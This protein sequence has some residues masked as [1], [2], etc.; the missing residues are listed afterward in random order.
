[1]KR[2]VMKQIAL[3]FVLLIPLPTAS[4]KGK[5]AITLREIDGRTWL[6]DTKGQPFFAHGVTHVGY[7]H[8]GEDVAEIARELKELGFNSYGYGCPD[9]LKSD[10]PYVQDNNEIALIAIYRGKGATFF[11]IFDP[12]EQAR[13]D[14][15]IEKQCAANRNNPNLIGYC[16]TDLAAW[17]L[18]NQTGT[19]WVEYIR[20]LP[21]QSHGKI[22]YQKFLK[23]WR[24]KDEQQRDLAFLTLIAREYFKVCGEANRRYDPDHLVFGDRYLFKTA[25]P[26]VIKESLPYI[27][28][29]AIQPN[30]KPGFPRKDFDRIHK[31]T[32]KPIILC[33]FK[34]TFKEDGRKVLGWKPVEN[35]SV[36]GPMYAQY[37]KGAFATPYIIGSFWCQPVTELKPAFYPSGYVKVG[38][39]KP[40][41]KPRPEFN[42]AV[43]DVNRYIAANAPDKRSRLNVLMIAVDDLRPELACYGAKHVLSPNFDRLASTGVR[44]DRAYCQQAVCGASRLSIM[45]G[46]YPTQT[47]EQSYHVRN[48]RQ[49]HPDVLTMNQHFRNNGFRAV[50]LGKIYHARAGA[51]ADESGWDEWINI[52]ET[53]YADPA[54]LKH[55]RTFSVHK[56]ETFL[57]SF[58]EALD[59]G[60]DQYADG[61][62][63]T[64][65]VELLSELAKSKEP[66]F[67]ALGFIKPHLPF[68]APKRY[69]DLYDPDSLS[70]PTGKSIPP[71]Y[72]RYAAN[73]SAWELKFYHDYEGKSPTGFSDGLNKRL[74]HG[75]AACTSYIDACLGRVLDAL[76]EA[77]LAK[78]TI[79]VL[80][81]DHGF[82]L[83]EHGSWSKHTNFETDTRVPLLVRIPGEANGTA[84]DSIIEMVDLYPTLCDLA[85]IP[86]PSHCQGRSFAGLFDSP[87]SQHRTSAYSAYPADG[88][89]S[90]KIASGMVAPGTQRPTAMAT[91]HSIRFGNYRYTEWRPQPN[92]AA[93][94][95]VLT[96]LDADPDETTNVAD[97]P[98]HAVA[99]QMGQQQ[100]AQHIKANSASTKKKEQQQNAS[101]VLLDFENEKQVAGNNTSHKA[102]VSLIE[103]TPES[104]GKY[105][106]KTVADSAANAGGY[107]GT[108][109][110]FTRTDLS[111]TASVSLWIKTNIEGSLNLQLHSG[112]N[113]N[114]GVSVAGFTTVGFKEEWKKVSVPLSRFSKPPWSKSEADLSNINR[115]QT[116]AFGNGPYDGKY[117]ILDNISVGGPVE[118]VG[119]MKKAAESRRELRAAR[120]REP[121]IVKRG[122]PIDMFDGKTLKGWFSIP[123]VYV[124]RNQKFSTMP[125]D[126]LFDA[127]MAHYANSDRTTNRIPDRERVADKGVWNVENGVVIGGQ[128]PGS[129]AGAYLMSE[130]KYGD[131]EL[132]LEANPDFPIDTGI[133]VR[134]HRLGTVGYQVLVD[135]RPNGTIGGV[136]G[137]SVG[138]FFAYP[139]VFDA[140]EEPLNRIAN[141]RSGNPNAMQ[142]RGGQL[143][144][145]FAAP[146]NE[147]LRI[148]KPN[149]WNEIKIR[150]TGRLPL[151]ET[152]INGVPIAKLDTETLADSV[153]GYDAEAIFKR[154]GRD[155]H[156]GLEVHDS[157]T[158]ERWAPGAKCRWRNVR[159]RELECSRETSENTTP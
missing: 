78:N 135:N 149:D 115:I 9:F 125:A 1:M 151:I 77:G 46:L 69:W 55:K 12:N 141:V 67:L 29:V 25:V 57:G 22:E 26:E 47:L 60:D 50:G 86:I 49:R 138:D 121:V 120:L 75:Y 3:L 88:N 13:I 83:G 105:A 159:I 16:W 80:W 119:D 24:G 157:P 97:Q 79:V 44:F 98:E 101:T 37:I 38:I 59:V 7:G 70:M 113:G 158:R 109:F 153:P 134:A 150:C 52:R 76:D 108:G 137:N 132:T 4:A 146:L 139:F 21:D 118:S 23:T 17:P 128:S 91:G 136:Y 45:T 11:D 30:F 5:T 51:D 89:V 106:V 81:G 74:L 27:D 73:L 87:R 28:A 155:G 14:R 36:A 34:V 35:A 143:R 100:L 31:L 99:L 53:M 68:V 18:K 56:P 116:T 144:T 122:E 71:G 111:K 124:P 43:R 82:K 42:N 85:G 20:S 6:V 54:N 148:W 61:Q 72:P 41:L 96:D 64:K 130:K 107:F 147:F 33:D 63:T 66:F 117:I 58:T 104:G 123:R 90:E 93:T 131:F 103:D 8:N 140:D 156:I 102:K 95:A 133:M 129:T 32:G 39:F 62:R 92:Q 126:Q 112:A 19:N 40:G 2:L 94:A 142:F 114:S 65:T 15:A 145:D 152:W 84:T 10:M 154:I 110:G 127:V 48:W